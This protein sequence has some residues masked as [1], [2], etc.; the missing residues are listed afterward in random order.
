M[1][2][3]APW[4]KEATNERKTEMKPERKALIWQHASACHQR[5]ILRYVALLIM[6]VIPD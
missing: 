4:Y 6:P 5:G 1:D 2:E 3:W